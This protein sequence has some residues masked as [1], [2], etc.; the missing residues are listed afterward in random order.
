MERHRVE[1]HKSVRERAVEIATEKRAG[2]VLKE[3]K[4][5]QNEKKYKSFLKE[6]EEKLR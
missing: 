4:D 3:R 1:L 5:R 6:E 2:Q